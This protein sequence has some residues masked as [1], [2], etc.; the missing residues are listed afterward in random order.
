VAHQVVRRASQFFAG[1]TTDFDERIVAVS[2]H[3]FGIGGGDQPLLGRES[4]FSLSNRLVVT[5]GLIVR[6]AFQSYRQGP[7]FIE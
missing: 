7:G 4:P 5:H 2:D 1:E 3:T 6:R